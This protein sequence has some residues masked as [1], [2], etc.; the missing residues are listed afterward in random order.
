MKRR[1]LAAWRLARSL[2]TLRAQ[3]DAAWPDRSKASDGTIGDAAHARRTSDH[4]PNARGVVC[5]LDITHDPA[6]GCDAGKI[7]AALRASRDPR[8]KYV[9]WDRKIFNSQ[10]WPWEW[11]DYRG[12]NPHTAHVHISVRDDVSDDVPWNINKKED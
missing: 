8:I 3:V 12:T 9:I 5:A 10:L 7:A 6:N 11:R 2:E 1:R 4:N